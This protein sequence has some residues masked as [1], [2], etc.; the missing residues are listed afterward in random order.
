M[1]WRP[2]QW[3][4]IAVL[5]MITF[6]GRLTAEN[7]LSQQFRRPVA[8]TS[9]GPSLVATANRR[10][11]SVS[12]VDI[13][14]GV[15]V[16]ELTVGGELSDI[17]AADSE[18]LLAI[19]RQQ[20]ALIVLKRKADTWREASRTPV[21]H[22]PVS[23]ELSANGQ[24]CSISSLWAR[25]LSIVCLKQDAPVVARTVDLTFAPRE[26]VFLDHR[27][28]LVAD[29]FGGK[30][31][32]IDCQTGSVLRER[33]LIAT[34]NI[35]GLAR[36]AENTVVATHQMLNPAQATT[37]DNVHWGDVMSNTIRRID[38]EWFLSAEREETTADQLYYLGHPDDATGDPTG[39]ELTEDGRQIVAFAGIDQV[40]VSDPGANFFRR[41]DVGRRP[42]ALLIRADQLIV[43]NRFDDSLSIIEIER[44]RVTSTIALGP[45]PSLAL[46][47][48]GEIL[49]H[50]SRLSSD[51][52]FSCHSCHTDGHTNGQLSDTFGDG[53]RGAPKRVLTL[54]GAAQTGPWAWN[55]KMPSMHS[56][57]SKSIRTTMRGAAPTPDQVDALAA[58]IRTL[59][60]APAVSLARGRADQAAIQRGR[61]VFETN[62]CADCHAPPTFSTPEVYDVGLEDS[63]GNR[64]FNPPSLRGVS[65]RDRL[66]HDRSART[67]REAIQAHAD[68]S[69]LS[70]DT[71][72]WSALT[73]FLDSL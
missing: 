21:A 49:F 65:Q 66:L 13:E 45:T 36:L 53:Y 46:S 41:V 22:T 51:G 50:D 55:G 68:G 71:A 64:D 16:N 15:I 48:R 69:S 33:E 19:D 5:V 12:V 27:R 60:P 61:E 35:S 32:V 17:C 25:Q 58:Y 2:T 28:L 31:A 1:N 14:R 67:Y 63:Y 20:H 9:I 62:G 10:S 29:A 30:V 4:L 24:L 73:S 59:Q 56:Q 54:L 8:M 37:G 72:D 26:Q 47:D 52:W 34:H 39:I 11:G 23:I 70:L 38:V 57:I 42:T 3:P 7:E 44:G 43:A 18:T 6:V 40:G